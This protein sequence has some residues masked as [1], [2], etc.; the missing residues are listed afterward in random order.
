M[1]RGCLPLGTSLALRI[2]VPSTLRDAVLGDLEEEIHEMRQA[3][4]SSARRAARA[5]T[6]VGRTLAARVR[7]A[8]PALALRR[9]G[10]ASARRQDTSLAA[11]RRDFVD[12][13]RGARR[14]PL[15]TALAAGVLALGLGG[16]A[17]VWSVLE[18]MVRGPLRYEDADRLVGFWAEGD[19]SLEEVDF[20]R[21]RLRSVEDLA[22]VQAF[23]EVS[24]DTASGPRLLPSASV[25]CEYFALLRTPAALGRA[26]AKSDC[27]AGA[28]PLALLS[29]DA[30][31]THFGGERDVIGKAQRLDGQPVAVVGVM[32]A[33]FVDPAGRFTLWRTMP[34]DPADPTGDYRNN[35]SF[36]VFGR[37]VAGADLAAAQADA[38]ALASDLGEAFRYP[39]DYD[40]S[41]DAAVV[42]LRE[43][44]TGRLAPPLRALLLAAG[45]VLGIACAN[46]ANLQLVR[47]LRRRN[48][49]LVRSALGASR[50]HLVRRLLAESTL[51]VL[52]AAGAG[53]LFA[54]GALAAVPWLLPPGTA[55]LD[56]VRLTPSALWLT[57]ALAAAAALLLAAAPAL[58]TRLSPAGSLR[59]GPDRGES[60]LRGG[61][62]VA[63]TAL[64]V[65]L[66][67]GALAAVRHFDRL[68]EVD[69]GFDAHDVT[70][71]RLE[72]PP[73]LA[74][75]E[76]NGLLER[77]ENRLGALPGVVAVGAVQRPPLVDGWVMPLEQEEHP[78]QR[79]DV[80][81]TAF[82]R[83]VS[84]SYFEAT[85][86]ELVRG[87]LLGPGDDAGAAP[88]ALV[89]EE[90][91]RRFF[92]DQDPLGRGVRVPLHEHYST[93]VGIVRD[94][95][96]LGPG[97]D[98]L[99]I[100]YQPYA[101]APAT[102][103]LAFVIETAEPT[104]TETALLAQSVRS[105]VA[106]VDPR[107]PLA[108]VEPLE[109]L[110]A[111][112]LQPLRS[113]AALLAALA[114][115]GVALGAVGLFGV[116]SQTVLARTRE[117]G[118]RI[119]VGASARQ[120][121][122]MVVRQ[123]LVLTALGLL[124]GFGMSFVLVRAV[125]TRLADFQPSASVVVVA[126][127]LLGA[128]TLAA[129]LLPALRAARVE[130][131]SALRSE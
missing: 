87:R 59:H 6:E 85:D 121:A 96:L 109:E 106:E 40:K 78:R 41:K 14:A 112:R 129:S 55:R 42:A 20:A 19:W 130:P 70:V 105:A 7:S 22:A 89:N 86:L 79:D 73:D 114:A 56:E 88:V 50:L 95:R 104:G 39:P 81:P 69:T 111:R 100:L 107:V 37:L 25:T 24:L 12:A 61:F 75:E 102:R 16:T 63:Q 21:E 3:G 43:Q 4:V 31:Q 98:G 27:T 82:W 123:S 62:V 53:L 67:V 99:A 17:A 36:S 34:S 28:P 44:L 101:Q 110:V 115:L 18:S 32:P 91:A 2:L 94:E 66:L 46:V 5:W 64:A 126:I 108:E 23:V 57:A 93:I 83:A 60:R 47:S 118:L 76:R 15:A 122:R 131:T 45:C 10:R 51:L 120:V 90:L 52:L 72:L 13:V 1:K 48:E 54:R 65:V 124:A 128:A 113:L 97:V 68:L 71:A 77:L 117:I 80:A 92:G 116:L 9:D 58:R 35:H 74:P 49:I 119:A 33:S 8:A 38:E 30:W 26:P 84:A 125:G 127:A 29:Y 103:S 11:W